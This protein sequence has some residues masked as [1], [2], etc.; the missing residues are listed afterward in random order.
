MTKISE[1]ANEHGTTTSSHICETCGTS[2]TVTP[3]APGDGEGYENCLA[4]DCDSY[5]LHRDLDILFQ[6]DEE[7]VKNVRA[8][9]IKKL[10]ARKH[11]KESG[12]IK[13]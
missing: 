3:G 10:R 11:F 2:F 13:V 12:E 9:C 7:I 1:C 5:D 4:P 6:T 8:V